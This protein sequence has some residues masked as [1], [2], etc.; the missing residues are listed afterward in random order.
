MSFRMEPEYVNKQMDRVKTL[1]CE[2]EEGITV[3]DT[4]PNSAF[5]LKEEAEASYFNLYRQ[6]LGTTFV[7]EIMDTAQDI[8]WGE[9]DAT[10]L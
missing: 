4:L 9:N 6:L 8:Y 1:I 2:A 10:G 3:R 7:R 5:P